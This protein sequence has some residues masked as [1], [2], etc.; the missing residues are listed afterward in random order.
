MDAS[1]AQLALADA[2]QLHRERIQD[3]HDEVA[4]RRSQLEEAERLLE[5]RHDALKAFLR[6]ME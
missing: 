2:M 6:A 1:K 5:M 3:A 4:L